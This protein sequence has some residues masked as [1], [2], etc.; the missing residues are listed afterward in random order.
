MFFG[1]VQLRVSAKD[2]FRADWVWFRLGGGGGSVGG[3]VVS[4]GWKFRGVALGD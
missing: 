4:G 2:E 1:G 3:E